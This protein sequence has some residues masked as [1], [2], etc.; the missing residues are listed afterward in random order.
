MKRARIAS[1]AW[2]WAVHQC[3]S[4]L[5]NL[6]KKT[7]FVPKHLKAWTQ[8]WGQD[9][10]AKKSLTQEVAELKEQVTALQQSVELLTA[11]FKAMV[12]SQEN[13]RVG[14][15]PAPQPAPYVPY[16]LPNTTPY[17]PGW[18]YGP[19]TSCGGTSQA[20]CPEVQSVW[21]NST[22]REVSQQHVQNIQ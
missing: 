19:T 7:K 15:M 5:F 2:A 22:N 3:H 13:S 1:G 10:M 14:I 17:T 16:P 12:Q 21:Y 9:Y 11:I 4:Q 6:S 20:A 18:P 8:F